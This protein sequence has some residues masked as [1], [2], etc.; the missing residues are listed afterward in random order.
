MY[1]R[2]VHRVT[3]GQKLDQWALLGGNDYL[4]DLRLTLQMVAYWIARGDEDELPTCFNEMVKRAHARNAVQDAISSVIR[5]QADAGLVAT[6]SFWGDIIETHSG[7][8]LVFV[9][10]RN[11]VFP[12]SLPA[13]D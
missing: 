1:K 12:I 4:D 6:D 7:L 9:P 3:I 2:Q 8:P 5:Q 10:Y 11:P 13:Y